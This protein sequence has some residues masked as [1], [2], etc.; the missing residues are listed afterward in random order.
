[1]VC[2]IETN[3]FLHFYSFG[4]NY[5]V[6]IAEGDVE[7]LGVSSEESWVSL[8]GVIKILSSKVMSMLQFHVE[9]AQSVVQSMAMNEVWIHESL[10]PYILGWDHQVLFH[11]M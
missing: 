7:E 6:E 2:G 11:L 9:G 4:A 1:M 5:R 10:W 8:I 3:V